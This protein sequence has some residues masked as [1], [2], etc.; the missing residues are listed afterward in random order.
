MPA[1]KIENQ[2]KRP[3][4]PRTA[5]PDVEVS[6]R[7]YTDRRLELVRKYCP[8]CIPDQVGVH[9]VVGGRAVKRP[10]GRYN[11]EYY[12]FW[13]DRNEKAQHRID[14]GYEPVLD[15]DGVQVN[16]RG[17][18][19]YRRKTHEW[20]EEKQPLEEESEDMVTTRMAGKDSDSRG[21][22][23]RADLPDPD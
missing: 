20:L 21:A 18:P 7:G 3:G 4:R 17:D 16:D 19:L 23:L 1:M 12:A 2:R 22:G 13:G 8:E 5:A 14:A 9:V 11:N 10:I 15:K 6:V